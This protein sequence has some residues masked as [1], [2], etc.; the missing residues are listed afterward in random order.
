[1]ADYKQALSTFTDALKGLSLDNAAKDNIRKE[2]SDALK[3]IESAPASAPAASKPQTGGDPSQKLTRGVTQAPG[4][5]SS[6]SFSD[7]PGALPPQTKGVA[8]IAGKTPGGTSQISFGGDTSAPQETKSSTKTMAP[9]GGKSSIGPDIK[10]FAP[11]PTPSPD[12]PVGELR[13]KV[14]TAIYG[15]GKLKDTFVKFGMNKNKISLQELK[16]GI[17]TYCGITITDDETKKLVS[18]C[19]KN[20]ND[21]IDYST[22]V[23]VMAV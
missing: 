18:K 17:K 6:I 2:I 14:S 15:K 7:A 22:F 13:Q 8:R 20:E 16:D 5:S 11:A 3:T 23:K 10:T 19:L 9:P 4:G 12:D 21:G 1:M